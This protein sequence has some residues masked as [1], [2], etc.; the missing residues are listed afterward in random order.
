MQFVE[1][2]WGTDLMSALLF[3]CLLF[4]VVLNLVVVRRLHSNICQS[5]TELLHLHLHLHQTEMNPQLR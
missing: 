3:G 1:S 2:Q 5:G 4:E